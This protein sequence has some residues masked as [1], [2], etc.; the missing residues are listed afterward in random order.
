MK[1]TRRVFLWFLILIN[2]SACD[3]GML[4][5]PLSDPQAD[6][7]ADCFD[8]SADNCPV[9]YNPSQVDLDDDGLGRACDETD[10]DDACGPV[11]ATS[12][13]DCTTTASVSVATLMLTDTLLQESS[14][15]DYIDPSQNDLAPEFELDLY[16]SVCRYVVIDCGG[17]FL[18]ELNLDKTITFAITNPSQLISDLSGM[19]STFDPQA[20]TPP[21]LYCNDRG[22]HFVGYIT[23][24]PTLPHAISVCAVM[25]EL[26]LTHFACQ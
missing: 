19:C 11:T 15:T 7:D 6:P 24:N 8:T 14:G 1:V 10:D 2:I 3:G 25:Q 21:I 16:S 12:D 22:S 23:M 5:G 26:G 9:T 20:T 4:C 13:G 18:G 17:E